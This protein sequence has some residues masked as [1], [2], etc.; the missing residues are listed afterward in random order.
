VAADSTS[1][2]AV[3]DGMRWLCWTLFVSVCQGFTHV[4]LLTN[5]ECLAPAS[6]LSLS[7]SLSLCVCQG[8]NELSMCQISTA[9][10][11][12]VRPGGFPYCCDA[13]CQMQTLCLLI[14]PPFFPFL[15]VAVL[16]VPS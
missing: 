5:A 6:S 16:S 4:L 13:A 7:L 15:P 8:C 1:L 12:T 10:S 14:L 3:G 11:R 2:V 9:P